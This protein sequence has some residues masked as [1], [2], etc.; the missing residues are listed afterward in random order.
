MEKMSLLKRFKDKDPLALA[1]AITQVE[2]RVE[3]FEE[4]LHELFPYTGSSFRIGVTG[5]PGAGKSTLTE[6]LTLELRKRHKSVGIIAVDPTSPFTGGAILGDRIRMQSVSLDP[7]VFIRSMAT[8][9]SMGGLALASKEVAD[10]MDAFGKEV[11][12][13][14]TVGV[15]Q[16]ELD[17]ASAAD[18]TVVVLVPES[19]DGVQ[20]MKAGLMEIADLFV[21]NKA[22]HQGAITLA[23]ELEAMLSMREC[24]DGWTPTIHRTVATTGQGIEELCD[25]IC[26][27]YQFLTAHGRLLKRRREGLKTHIKDIITQKIHAVLWQ[28]PSI[29]KQ[30][31][32]ALDKITLNEDTPYSVADKL[33]DALNLKNKGL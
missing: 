17:I 29:C 21:V 10:V 14:E 4:L 3:G 2:N 12:I 1:R 19:G 32:K 5:P 20:A 26:V 15:G 13:M 9:G 30:L 24:H 25:A 8:R 22:D 16:S 28:D 33:L 18:T 27:H 23:R 7:E 6:K 11:V 31:E